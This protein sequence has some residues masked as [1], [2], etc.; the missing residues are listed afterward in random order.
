[1][2]PSLPQAQELAEQPLVLSARQWPKR[3]K[4][5]TVLSALF[6]TFITTLNVIG[7][8]LLG[9]IISRELNTTYLAVQAGNATYV[10]ALAIAPLVLAPLSESHGRKPVFLIAVAIYTLSIIPQALA[11][12]VALIIAFRFISGA[13]SS[14][15]ASMAGGTV[16]DTFAPEESAFPMALF[17]L[18]VWWGQGIG[19]VLTT[20]TITYHSWRIVAWWNLA[21]GGLTFVLLLIFMGETRDAPPR[22]RRPTLREIGKTVKIPLMMLLK[23]PVVQALA[24]WSAFLWSVNYIFVQAIP[25]VFK[26]GYQWTAVQQSF[27]L[28]GAVPAGALGTLANSHQGSI[29]RRKSR[30]AGHPRPDV[31]LYYAC[32]GAIFCPAAI[33][34]FAWTGRP[35][36]S[37]AAPI[38]GYFLYSLALFPIY[39][40]LFAY[41]ADIYGD[42]A[43]S[44]MAAQSFLRNLLAALLPLVSQKIYTGLG[45]SLAGTVLGSIAAALA[46]VPFVL[47]RYGHRLQRRKTEE[48]SEKTATPTELT[49]TFHKG[50]EDQR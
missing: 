38:I 37:P 48:E 39:T 6:F 20:W 23:E 24:T 7:Y 4:W 2:D 33:F 35:S 9:D 10:S 22:E 5:A 42:Q 46:V 29:Y 41:L 47:M 21:T 30:K 18:A 36:I 28:L 32:V 49:T 45:S 3:K 34:L 16:S 8:P 13:A 15:G 50:L 1:M 17:S 27:V 31:R 19:P 43:S 14:V 26:G 12:N 44:A 40:T 25:F 11:N